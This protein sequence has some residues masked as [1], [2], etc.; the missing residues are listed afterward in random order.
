MHKI[1][2]VYAIGVAE[3]MDQDIKDKWKN[4]QSL[5]SKGRTFTAY[6]K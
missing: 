2:G 4:M 3:C 5:V 6:G 1:W